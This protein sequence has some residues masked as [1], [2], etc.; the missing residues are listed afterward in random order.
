MKRVVLVCLMALVTV[1]MWTGSPLLALWIGSRVQASG[2]PSM[3]AVGVAAVSLGVL[4]YVLVKLLARLDAVY[5]R[6]AGRPT[7]VGRH[8]PWLRSMRGERPHQQRH[9]RE[10]SPLEII[11]IVT[12]VVVVALFE[13]WFF[14]Y[15]SSPIDQR[16][17]RGHDVPLIGAVGDGH[18]AMGSVFS[19]PA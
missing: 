10:L 6:V 19:R 5:A 11:L 13:V 4:T 15:S 17:G 12:V 7:S 8:V 16:S 18:G 14:F 2:P 9:A 1:N 3:L